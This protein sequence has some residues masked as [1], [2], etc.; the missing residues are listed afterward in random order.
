MNP[1]STLVFFGSGAAVVLLA[2]TTSA[3]LQR[4]AMRH[5]AEV[6]QVHTDISRFMFAYPK[7]VSLATKLA[8][9]YEKEGNP[10][11][12]LGWLTMGAF[13][14]DATCQTKAKAW[15]RLHCPNA[16]IHEDE[17]LH[18]ADPGRPPPGGPTHLSDEQLE[19]LNK[20]AVEANAKVTNT[21]EL[22]CVVIEFG[23][24]IDVVS[25]MAAAT[26]RPGATP[27]EDETA[28]MGW[29]LV[30][31]QRGDIEAIAKVN[32][33]LDQHRAWDVE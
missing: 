9:H 17:P 14:G 33:W 30:G 26:Q 19:A 21:M 27:E 20:R 10:W 8:D 3:F 24:A 18:E 32:Q 11:A 6:Q 5:D 13:N 25:R 28:A 29:Y 4:D 31:K 15:L 7:D 22:C 1:L 2:S 23:Y 16:Q 12:S